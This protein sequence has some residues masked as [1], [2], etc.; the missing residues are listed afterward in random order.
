MP[1]TS[2]VLLNAVMCPTHS[3]LGHVAV[4]EAA[5]TVF[6]VDLGIPFDSVGLASPDYVW[7]SL[8]SSGRV[9]A[10]GVRLGQEE[11]GCFETREQD[12]LDFCVA[13]ARAEERAYGHWL[14]Q[15]YIGDVE[16][17]RRGTGN[18]DAMEPSEF[19]PM[20]TASIA[21]VDMHLAERWDAVR[22]VA[23]ALR[24]SASADDPS[25]PGA[26]SFADVQ[27]ILAI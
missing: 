13:G 10:G 15:S 20:L 19:G 26:L 9:V 18:L 22:T 24:S 25:G 23:D 27:A 7:T 5:H 3:W 8:Q 1:T 17:W 16:L 14:N 11:R 4:H 21:R 6:A 12:G 2:T